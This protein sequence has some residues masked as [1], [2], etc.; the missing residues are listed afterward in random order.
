MA[1][2]GHKPRQP[3]SHPE[4]GSA[5]YEARRDGPASVG[6]INRVA[7]RC[8]FGAPGEGVGGQ[9]D[10][11]SPCH[12]KGKGWVP[13]SRDIEKGEDTVGVG[14]SG[15]TRPAPKIRPNKAAGYRIHLRPQDA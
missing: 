5:R 15:M 2:P 14:Y 4:D 13:I 10:G 12:H 7:K 3:P 1:G 8:G 9:S 6:Q 11:D